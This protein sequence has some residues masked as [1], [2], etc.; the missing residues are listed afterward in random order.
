MARKK[1]WKKYSMNQRRDYYAKKRDEHNKPGKE[2][3]QTYMRCQGYL[4]GTQR[5]DRSSL[6]EG[7]SHLPSYRLGFEMGLAARE[8]QDNVKF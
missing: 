8:K 1:T 6:Y 4:D 2:N 3:Q 5:F 7:S